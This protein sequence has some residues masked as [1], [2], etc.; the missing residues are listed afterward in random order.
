MVTRPGSVFPGER[1]NVLCCCGG[2]LACRPGL[3]QLP[4][5]DAVKTKAAC[6]RLAVTLPDPRRLNG[7]QPCSSATTQKPSFTKP[8]GSRDQ[9]ARSCPAGYLKLAF[10]ATPS[11]LRPPV[12]IAT[13]VLHVSRRAEV[14][15]HIPSRHQRRVHAKPAQAG[16]LPRTLPVRAERKEASVTVGYQ[17]GGLRSARL[18]RGSWRPVKLDPESC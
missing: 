3:F 17:D 6:T 4:S 11:D 12:T 16:Q 10:E 7:K 18:G 9:V 14:R 5:G 13:E 2:E 1:L 15:K 8:T